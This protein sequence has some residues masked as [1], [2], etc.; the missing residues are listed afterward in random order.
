MSC[1]FKIGCHDCFCLCEICVFLIGC[2]A[3]YAFVAFFCFFGCKAVGHPLYRG[4][5]IK[6]AHNVYYV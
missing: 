3:V 6:K 2:G 5:N 4:Y 1:G